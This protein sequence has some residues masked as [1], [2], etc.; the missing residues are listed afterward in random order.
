MVVTEQTLEVSAPKEHVQVSKVDLKPNNYLGA[1]QL[2]SG[3][4]FLNEAR[5]C[6]YNAL[7]ATPFRLTPFLTT[8]IYLFQSGQQMKSFL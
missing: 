2:P 5:D 7:L 4:E 6:S 8:K 3:Q 1:F